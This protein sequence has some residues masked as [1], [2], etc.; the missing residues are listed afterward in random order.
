[1]NEA[2]RFHGAVVSSRWTQGTLLDHLDVDE[3]RISL[4]PWLRHSVILERGSI[5]TVEFERV[6]LPLVWRTNVLF[7][8]KDGSHAPKLFAAFRVNRL[9]QALMD[10]GWP[11]VELPPRTLNRMWRKRSSLGSSP[12]SQPTKG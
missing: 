1:M 11:V 2:R 12:S 3:E 5:E 8:H 7:R 9:T 6:R 10:L 4:R